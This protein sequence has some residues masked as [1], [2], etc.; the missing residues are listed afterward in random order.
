MPDITDTFHP[1]S[2]E[3]LLD[4]VE[5]ALPDHGLRV[6]DS[7][8]ALSHGGARYFGLLHV[9]NGQGSDDFGAV[10][11]IRN[12]ADKRFAAGLV[13]GAQ[14]FVC[15]NLAFTGEHQLARK[16]TS[17]IEDELPHLVMSTLKDLVPSW[18][19][20]RDRVQEYKSRWLSDPFCH[21]LLVKSLDAGVITSRQ[22]PKVLEQWRRPARQEFV[23]AG[24]CI[25]RYYNAV[26]EVL[27]GT[28]LTTLSNRTQELH[29]VIDGE[30]NINL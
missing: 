17:R 2:H 22:I 9:A 8:H 26:T 30:C 19:K 29:K 5:Q 13:A 12:S 27:K 16:H 18:A 23:E 7:A 14:V 1:I 24:N 4:T 28:P 20:H 15:D 25:W 11:G 6:V 21:D 10:L 3:F